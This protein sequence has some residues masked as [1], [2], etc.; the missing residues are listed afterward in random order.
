MRRRLVVAAITV[1][2]M[3]AGV[4]AVAALTSKDSQQL[5]QDASGMSGSSEV[6]DFFAASL[7][8]GDFNGDGRGDVI[9]G[10]PYE[11]IGKKKRDA[12]V[13]H[14][15]YGT[16]SG[17]STSNDISLDPGSPGVKGSSKAGDLF[18]SAVVVGDFDNDGYDDAVIGSPGKKRPKKAG[19]GAITVL[20]GSRSG[21]RA[22]QSK[23]FTAAGKGVRGSAERWANFGSSLAVG[24]FDNDGYDDVAVGAPGSGGK[25]SYDSGAVH[26]FYGS[27]KGITARGD[28]RIDQATSGVDGERQAG[29]SFGASLAA[30]DFDG[31]G[32]DDLAVGIPG[33]ASNGA[34]A[35]GAVQVF[36]GAKSG[37]VPSSGVLFTQA[38]GNIAGEPQA[39]DL[40][41]S[42][43]AAGDYNGD[44]RDDLA[45]GVPGQ[46]F[47]N[48][49]GAGQVHVLYG[50]SKGLSANGTRSFDQASKRIKSKPQAG[51]GFGTT[52][53]AGDYNDNGRDDLAIGVPGEKLGSKTGAG[54]VHVLFG[55]KKGLKSTNQQWFRPG[56]KGLPGKRQANAN[57]GRALAAGDID[58]DGRSD[59]VVGA[60]GQKVGGDAGA[61]RLTVIFG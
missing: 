35:A 6:G 48:K 39:D 58:G 51:D 7:A 30:G 52:L 53:A 2:A 49:P 17:L 28:Q 20:Y 36:S 9:A 60:P 24:D 13:I 61:G 57:F 14:V 45:V 18:G 1:L 47:G 22:K 43:L 37:L 23:T 38:S 19:A 31:D 41:G 27:S 50:R 42:A 54:V 25:G 34:A 16:T 40:F 5:S 3:A 59:L 8:I 29:D 56:R 55:T 11:N 32:R 21:L 33:E 12:G 44:G 26:I 4:T 10:A 15:L 46:A